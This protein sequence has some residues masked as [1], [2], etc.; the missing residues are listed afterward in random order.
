MPTGRSELAVSDPCFGTT[1][2]CIRIFFLWYNEGMRRWT[3]C[4]A[5]F[6]C[7]HRT[8]AGRL[9]GGRPLRGA[10]RLRGGRQGA[11]RPLH[12]AKF[13]R[14]RGERQRAAAPSA[15]PARG[16]AP[17]N[18][19]SM[20]PLTKCVARMPTGRSELAVSDPCFGTT[21]ACAGTAIVRQASVARGFGGA[22]R[23]QWGARGA[24][25]A[26]MHPTRQLVSQQGTGSAT[27]YDPMDRK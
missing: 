3:D 16:A 2:A 4:A 10:G 15:L 24:K 8:K 1:E 20:L 7:I 11:T 5:S 6:T 12:L 14:L 26:R 27:Q 25:P 23:P 22:L 9:R 21:K 13:I 18:P 19:D 17:G